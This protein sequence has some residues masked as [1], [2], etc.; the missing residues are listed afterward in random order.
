MEKRSKYNQGTRKIK[1]KRENGNKEGSGQKKKTRKTVE[2]MNFGKQF[3]KD[4]EV[5]LVI[6]SKVVPS[7]GMS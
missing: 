3:Q 6:I 5:C 2:K 4:T 1:E 7:L